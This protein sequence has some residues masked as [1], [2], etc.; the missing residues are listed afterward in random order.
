MWCGYGLKGSPSVRVLQVFDSPWGPNTGP[1]HL[2]PAAVSA[3]A[4]RD[5]L[6]AEIT[7]ARWKSIRKDFRSGKYIRSL[8]DTYK[9][10]LADPS[11][12]LSRSHGVSNISTSRGDPSM[13]YHLPQ[14]R[15]RSSNYPHVSKTQYDRTKHATSRTQH[16][17]TITLMRHLALALPM[18]EYKEPLM[19]RSLAR[20]RRLQFHHTQT[21]KGMLAT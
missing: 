14:L 9:K 18:A 7:N 17:R 16:A 8:I 21:T 6:E 12:D 13:S 15:V 20:K 11:I 10:R 19:N 1:E 4:L 5:I 2:L 3:S